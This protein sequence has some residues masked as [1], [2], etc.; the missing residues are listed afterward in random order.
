[1]TLFEIVQ[2]QDAAALAQ[3][4]RFTGD[5]NVVGEGKTTPLIEA[6]K[7]GWT[8]GVAAL[9]AAGAEPGWKDEAEETALLKAAANGHAEVARLLFDS[10]SDDERDLARAFLKAF[11]ATHAPEYQYDESRLKQKA[12]EVA[13]RAANFVGYEE[14]LQRLERVERS[15]KK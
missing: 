2:A 5:V 4:L 9:L 11:G 8:D 12:A 1:M 15:K 3:Q 14:P 10:A 7:L 6:A 13:A